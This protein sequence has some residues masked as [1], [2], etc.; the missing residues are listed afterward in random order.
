VGGIDDGA[1]CDLEVDLDFLSYFLL[2]LS[3]ELPRL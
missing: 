1:T 2:L 3:L